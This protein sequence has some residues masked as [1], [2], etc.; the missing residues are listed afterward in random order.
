MADKF[1]TLGNLAEYSSN[2]DKKIREF[3]NDKVS[4]VIH[5]E[6]TLIKKDT[7]VEGYISSY[8]LTKTEKLLVL[9]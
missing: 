3:V 5:P 6:Y 9:R 2:T 1:I 8:N 7:A 4:E